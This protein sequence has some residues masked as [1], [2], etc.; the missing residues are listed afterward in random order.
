[1]PFYGSTGATFSGEE[2]LRKFGSNTASGA[3][4]ERKLAAILIKSGLADDY[5]IWASIRT[6]S[7]KN[8]QGK[9]YRTDIDFAI[10]NGNRLV[11][12]DAKMWS[13]KGFWWSF[14]N[15]PFFNFTPFMDKRT[16][17]WKPLSGNMAMSVDRFRE[18]LPGCIVEGMVVFTPTPPRGD[19][20]TN[21][22]FMRWPGG[23]R[24]FL[25]S[26]AVRRIKA[27]LGEPR[28]VDDT[29]SAKLT[30]LMYRNQGER[31]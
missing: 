25:P 20:P 1:M 30:R 31:S 17:K 27:F 29:I 24:S 9:N 11:I 19:L 23:I 5:S 12:I 21:V 28:I 16:G 6:P 4:G 7:A 8:G 22:F 26:S 2:A 14:G 3:I 10:A 15:L 18:T 13:S